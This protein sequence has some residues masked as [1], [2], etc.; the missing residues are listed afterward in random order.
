MASDPVHRHHCYDSFK[1][2]SV[3]KQAERFSRLH[4]SHCS[5]SAGVTNNI[6]DGSVLFEC[7]GELRASAQNT[8]DTEV[9]RWNAAIINLITRS[10]FLR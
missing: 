6:N 9:A 8:T 10:F 1:L 5:E 3:S 4:P 2:S 7:L